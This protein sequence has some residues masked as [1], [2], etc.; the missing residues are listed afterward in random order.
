MRN[1]PMQ[2]LNEFNR[3][4]SEF[5]GDPEEAVKKLVASGKISQK[6]L[7]DLQTAAQTFKGLFNL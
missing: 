1:N 3:F 5:K 7:N 4:K 6:Q 2:M